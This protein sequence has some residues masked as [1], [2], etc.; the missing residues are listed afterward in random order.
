MAFAW[1]G[2]DALAAQSMGWFMQRNVSEERVDRRQSGVASSGA[3]TTFSLEMLEEL[4]DKGGVEILDPQGRRRLFEP[5][6]CE[7]QQDPEGVT[8]SSYG[9]GARLSLLEQPFGEEGLEESREVG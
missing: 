5:L 7:L 8:V 6:R 2:K 3:V 1:Y 4:A 9:V